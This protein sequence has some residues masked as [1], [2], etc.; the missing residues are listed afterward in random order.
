MW[1]NM[2]EVII[3]KK[4]SELKGFES[5]LDT[6]YITKKGE[7][8]S[9]LNDMFLKQGDNGHGYKNIG[10]KTLIYRLK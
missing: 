7:V 10:L 4:I 8:Y 1:Y 9:S 6:Y 3:L 5:T 2:L